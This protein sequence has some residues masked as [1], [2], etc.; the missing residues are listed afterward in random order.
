MGNSTIWLD[1]Q[2]PSQHL[3]TDVTPSVRCD[4]NAGGRPVRLSLL[5]ASLFPSSGG[6]LLGSSLASGCDNPSRIVDI[7]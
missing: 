4:S 2:A 1:L 6:R 5:V 3:K 7:E